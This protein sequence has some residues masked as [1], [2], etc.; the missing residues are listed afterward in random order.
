M[1]GVLKVGRIVGL[2]LTAGLF[3]NLPALSE[4]RRPGA[5]AYIIPGSF[6]ATRIEERLAEYDTLC[7]GVY[8]LNAGGRLYAKPSLS[9]KARTVIA[10]ARKGKRLFPLIALSG[11]RDGAAMLRDPQTRTFAADQ[12]A[13]LVQAHQYDG[14]HI[15]FEYLRGESAPDYAAFLAALKS[16]PRMQ[17]LT[18]SIAAFPPLHATPEAAEFFDLE[19]IGSSIDEIVYMTYDYHLERP[20][21]VTDLAWARRN[22]ELVLE[23]FPA[24]K[25]WLGVPAY[26]YAWPGKNSG[27]AGAASRPRAV[28]EGEGLE[29]CR[30][31][32][33]VRHESGTLHVQR[34]DRIVY[35]A[36]GETRKQMLELASDLKLRGT[37]MWRVGFEVF[38]EGPQESD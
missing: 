9:K 5:W 26:G 34:E 27:P 11:A 35:F 21:P 6:G 2:L 7:L 36:D 22:M 18:L 12:V 1:S 17:G 15:D 31:F 30:R 14:V 32:G 13:E 4:E 38:E 3:C 25:I 19:I 8:R 16:H 28:S 10:K 37:A 24:E 29:Q 20:G 23:N 33:C